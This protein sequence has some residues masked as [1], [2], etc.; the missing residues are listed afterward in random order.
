MDLHLTTGTVSFLKGI[1]E[2]HP[3]LLINAIGQDAVL[4]YEDDNEESLFNSGRDYSILNSE[5]QLNNDYPLVVSTIPVAH[6][7]RSSTLAHL[8]DLHFELGKQNGLVAHR[9]GEAMNRD[10][11]VVVTNWASREAYIDFKDTDTFKE[12][13][14]SDVLHKFRNA[15]SLFQDYISSKLYLPLRDNIEEEDEEDY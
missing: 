1:L 12:Y 8:Q 2:K 10:T 5:G 13:L 4:Y 3:E 11:F 15:E 9:I 7:N 6:S 14:S